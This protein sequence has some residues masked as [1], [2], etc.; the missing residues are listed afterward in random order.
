MRYQDTIKMVS[1]LPKP[2]YSR[3]NESY[4]QYKKILDLLNEESISGESSGRASQSIR[5][6]VLPQMFEKV[7]RSLKYDSVHKH[8]YIYMR[9]LTPITLPRSRCT[10]GVTSQQYR[11]TLTKICRAEGPTNPGRIICSRKQLTVYKRHLLFSRS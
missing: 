8:I 3:F 4:S 6:E 10:R 7:S 2:Y 9:T 11:T 5:R 1:T